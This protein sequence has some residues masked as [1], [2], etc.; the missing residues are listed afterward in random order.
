MSITTDELARQR[1][2][3]QIRLIQLVIGVLPK[4][5]TY[6]GLTP[7]QHLCNAFD[8]MSGSDVENIL[9]MEVDD[10]KMRAF[11]LRYGGA[12]GQLQ[13]FY[14]RVFTADG[15]AGLARAIGQLTYGDDG[16]KAADYAA[17]ILAGLPTSAN[18]PSLPT[19]NK[20]PASFSP[21]SVL[22]P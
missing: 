10:E 17:R 4:T 9:Q 6:M 14:D 20:T 12:L 16:A 1:Q 19:T 5:T 22:K 2:R 3:F 21:G 11:A 18:P 7:F 15:A 13:E 8:T